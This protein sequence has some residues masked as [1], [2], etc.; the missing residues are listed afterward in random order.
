V[1]SGVPFNT[2]ERAT[3]VG[4]ARDCGTVLGGNALYVRT[5]QIRGGRGYLH[6]QGGLHRGEASATVKITFFSA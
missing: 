1:S 3:A 4:S 2:R 6:G 5:A